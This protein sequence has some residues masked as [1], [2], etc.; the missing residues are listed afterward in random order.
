MWSSVCLHL[1]YS[2]EVELEQGRRDVTNLSVALAE[3]VSRLIEGADQVMRLV[4]ADFTEDPDK[5][6]FA[7]WMKRS[8]SLN[9]AAVQIAIFDERGDLVASRNPSP[10]LK[11]AR[12]NVSDRAYFRHLAE[13]PEA[14]LYI[15]RA[16]LG[17]INARWAF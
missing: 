12:P 16:L 8:T 6:D 3:Q 7:T 13:H 4:Q 11:A 5:F 10:D 17:R 1:N 9:E 15:D 2:Y 14:G